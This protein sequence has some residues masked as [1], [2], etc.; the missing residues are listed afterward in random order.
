MCMLNI[1]CIFTLYM[2]ITPTVIPEE[3]TA[4]CTA[5]PM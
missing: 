2:Q 4:L 1:Q 3:T 5:S